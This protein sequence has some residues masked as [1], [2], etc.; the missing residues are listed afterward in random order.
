MGKKKKK[1]NIIFRGRSIWTALLGSWDFWLLVF[2]KKKRKKKKK[3]YSILPSPPKNPSLAEIPKRV[4]YLVFSSWPPT[5]ALYHLFL[6]ATWLLYYSIPFLR[7]RIFHT[8]INFAISISLISS[9]NYCVFT[10]SYITSSPLTPRYSII[11]GPTILQWTHSLL[12]PK[13]L[14]VSS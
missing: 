8:G 1:E 11:F 2:S 13:S 9:L 4:V 7:C 10:G 14:C 5:C 12:T 6:R 3:E